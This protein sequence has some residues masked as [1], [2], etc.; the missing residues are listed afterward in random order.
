MLT[1]ILIG[2]LVFVVVPLVIA[3]IIG[4]AI[5]LYERAVFRLT[6]RYTLVD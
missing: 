1:L 6:G 5:G 2:L 4:V 3:G